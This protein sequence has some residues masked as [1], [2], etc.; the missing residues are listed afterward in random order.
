MLRAFFDATKHGSLGRGRRKTRKMLFCLAEAA[1][2]NVRAIVAA[3][4]SMTIHSDASQNRLLV[5]TQTC[6]DDLEQHHELLGTADLGDDCS[7]AGIGSAVLR[8]L[9]DLTTPLK[10]APFRSGG[11]A[12]LE[13]DLSMLTHLCDTIEVFNADAAADEQLAGRMLQ[14][15][16]G[17]D[18]GGGDPFGGGAPLSVFQNLKVINKDKPHGARR[19]LSRTWKRDPYLSKIATNTVMA[20]SSIA[21]ILQHSD[22]LRARYAK[23]VRELQ[24]NPVWNSR[25][26]TLSAAKHRFDSWTKPFSR[27]CLAFEAVL[28]TAQEMHEERRNEAA[29]KNAK[30]FLLMVDEEMMLSLAMMADAGEETLELVRFLDS[31]RVPTTDIAAACQRFLERVTVLFEIGDCV[32]CG[33]TSF[34]LAVLEKQRLLFIDRKAKRIGGIRMLPIVTRCLGRLS[35]WVQLAREVLRAEFPQFE[36][37]QAFGALRLQSRSER[38]RDLAAQPHTES[39]RL[40]QVDQLT[41]IAQLLGLDANMLAAQFFDNLPTAQFVFDDKGCES[42]TAWCEAVNATDRSNRKKRSADLTG[43]GALRAVLIRAL[44]W[45]PSTSGVERCFGVIRR[46]HTKYRNRM[47]ENFVRDERAVLAQRERTP[48]GIP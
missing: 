40:K 44:A 12:P 45:G 42:V 38:R 6:G 11:G 13:C 35:K 37:V 23:H 25:M 43:T 27:L 26:T 14:D 5:L 36:I 47:E 15:G 10:G 24:H 33:H 16:A 4:K 3:A 32:K 9:R 31:D 39:E 8:I 1:R 30:A 41:K 17:A 18:P 7:A 22:V 20:K 46:T 28:C 29:G 48:S 21:Q 34:M 2:D 19:L